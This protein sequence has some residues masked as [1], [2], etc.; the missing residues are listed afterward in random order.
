[1]KLS[2]RISYYILYAL[3]AIILIVLGLYY[4]G[5]EMDS[6]IVPELSNPANTEA[7]IFLMYALLGLTVAAT[8]IAFLAQFVASLKENPVKAIKS[9]AGVVFLV[10]VL[11]VSWVLGSDT[12]L[13]LPGYEG[14]DNVPFWLKLTDMFIYS[15]YFLLF[16]TIASIFGSS[17]KKRFS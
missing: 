12:P 1:M 6:P 7:L 14:T 11:V 3:F 10:I 2:Y 16:V 9:L 13:V 8:V 15:I 17:I 4:F 5:G